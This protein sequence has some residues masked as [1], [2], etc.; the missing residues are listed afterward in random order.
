VIPHLEN[1]FSRCRAVLVLGCA[2]AL[3]APAFPQEEERMRILAHGPWPPEVRKDLRNS[4]SGK[5]AAI[6][7]GEKLFFEPSLSGTGSVLCATC[8][9]PYRRFQD[10]RQRA[11]GLQETERN[12]PTL[13]D[14]AF[15]PRFGWEGARD[16]LWSQSIRPLLEPREMRSSAGHVA[17]YVR[18]RAAKNYEKA[19]GRPPPDDD[20]Q[21][22]LDVGK[23]LAA[24]QETL[25]SR[26]T[27]F[28][29]YRDALARDDAAAMRAYPA[30]A[31][32][33]LRI[34][35]GRCGACHAG[36]T[37]SSG[38]IV[39]G[40]RIPALRNV[41]ATAPYMHDGRTASLREAVQHEPPPLSAQEIG[42]LVAFLESLSS[43]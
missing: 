7:F 41:A 14:V 27:P 33:G 1:R 25:V 38:A 16:T 29:K 28:D 19:F 35:V 6:A 12:T 18:T 20:E 26:R 24:F 34:F 8:H 4:V 15:Y 42:D 31:Q 11:F 37:F 23:A 9:V 30:P 32:R 13:L 5:T 36:P 39:R 17:T 22:L 2:L 40:I 43:D 10:S 3:A 21:I